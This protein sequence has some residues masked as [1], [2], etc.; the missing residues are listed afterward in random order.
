MPYRER[1]KHPAN[2]E[3][4][5]TERFRCHNRR[6]HDELTHAVR[7]REEGKPEEARSILL[8]L[9][10]KHPDDPLVSYQCAWVHDVLGLE[11]EA[12]PF[13]ERAIANGLAGED[14]EGAIVSLG[15]SYR[16]EDE[17]AKSV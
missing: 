7:L 15:S 8:R 2:G 12:V 13:Y 14:L 11:R 10:E 16:V 9:M 6:M 17:Y 4:T 3:R 1:G 5:R